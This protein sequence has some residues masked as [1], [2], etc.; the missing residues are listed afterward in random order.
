MRE[1]LILTYKQY[2]IWMGKTYLSIEQYIF[3]ENNTATGVTRTSQQKVL[4]RIEQ[5]ENKSFIEF[6]DTV[7]FSD[8]R[9]CN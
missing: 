7:F 6:N 9:N 2:L 3:S 1:L 8:G 4:G 5:V